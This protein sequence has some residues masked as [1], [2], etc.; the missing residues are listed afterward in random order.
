MRLPLTL[1]AKIVFYFRRTKFCEGVSKFLICQVIKNELFSGFSIS[2]FVALLIL[3]R[4]SFTNYCLHI[5][6]E[7]KDTSFTSIFVLFAAFYFSTSFSLVFIFFFFLVI[8]IF[9]FSFKNALKR[10]LPSLTSL[11]FSFFPFYFFFLLMFSFFL[12]FVFIFVP[13]VFSF[14]FS[15]KSSTPSLSLLYLSLKICFP[16]FSLCL[17][18]IFSTLFLCL[19]IF[20][21]YFFPC[22]FF[23]AK[24]KYKKVIKAINKYLL[25]KIIYV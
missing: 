24:V 12:F 14:S 15:T 19:F 21:F 11:T 6:Q 1:R 3:K 18:S 4:F 7:N 25:A 8:N 23:F 16:L 9:P 5:L 13:F 17:L 10:S 2:S 20:V 22:S